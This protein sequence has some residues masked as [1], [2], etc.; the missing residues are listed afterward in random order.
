M[1]EMEDRLREALRRHAVSVDTP[2]RVPAGLIHRAGVRIA[3]NGAIALVAVAVVAVGMVGGVHA[4]TASR[5][6]PTSK[7][8][9][10]PACR[11]N[12]LTG[13]SNLMISGKESKSREGVLVVTNEG[14]TPCSVQDRPD[15]RVRDDAGTSPPL[16]TKKKI[17]PYWTTR[18]STPPPDWPVVT[19]QP[20]DRA[21]IHV[22]WTNWCGGPDNPPVRWE[23]QL[24][25]G[26]GVVRVALNHGQ[27]IPNC[28][29][30]SELST[31]NWG[32]F[33]P[34]VPLT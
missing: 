33:E 29:G 17:D 12:Q 2:R 13:T 8:H 34:F 11:A 27:D 23:I 32:P 6:T 4:L 28:T 14:S 31:L 30:A 5:H 22:K 24:S 19:L 1:D 18:G 16:D 3:R 10:A 7:P 26:R 25:G 9:L 20:G 21:E 15:V